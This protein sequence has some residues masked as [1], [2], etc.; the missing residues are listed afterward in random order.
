MNAE[1][2]AESDQRETYSVAR[3]REAF[4]EHAR[5]DEWGVPSFYENG[6]IDA[7]R[8]KYDPPEACKHRF[9]DG[10]RCTLD[11]EAHAE[12][13]GLAQVHSYPPADPKEASDG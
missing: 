9:P 1:R 12:V 7:L 11:A 4:R 5:G 8:G 2:A 6:L 3:I 13:P 10:T